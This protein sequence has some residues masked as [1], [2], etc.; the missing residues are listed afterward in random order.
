MR[1]YLF[2]PTK[3]MLQFAQENFECDFIKVAESRGLE[4]P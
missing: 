1:I 3:T 2:E 4:P